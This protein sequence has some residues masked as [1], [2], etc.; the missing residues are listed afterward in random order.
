MT[1]S[2]GPKG[3]DSVQTGA[4][5]QS[6]ASFSEEALQRLYSISEVERFATGDT[7]MTEGDQDNSVYI[8][9]EGEAEVTIPKKNGWLKVANLVPGSV[10]GEL[11]FF[12]QMPR[13]AR[14]SVL[15]DCT[16]LKISENAFQQLLGQ[17]AATAV[18][19]VLEL[20]RILSLRLRNMNRLAQTLAR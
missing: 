17:D 19:L 15:M 9:L 2:N 12:D 1:T 8:V 18:A 4:I 16:T 13:S 6:L 20:G 7:V 5:S 10:F 3:R 11:S 14:V